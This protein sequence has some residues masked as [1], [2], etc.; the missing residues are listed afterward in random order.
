MIHEAVRRRSDPPVNMQDENCLPSL[1]SDG[2]SLTQN[3][4]GEIASRKMR[5]LKHYNDA[6]ARGDSVLLYAE[7]TL[8]GYRVDIKD[9]S[10]GQWHSLCRR[11]GTYSIEGSELN[12]TDEGCIQLGM[13]QA[14]TCSKDNELFIN[15]SILTWRGW[16]LV[17]PRPGKS[18]NADTSGSPVAEFANEPVTQF[19]LKT[20]FKAAPGSLP[21]LRFGTGYF[22]RARVVDIAGNSVSP[23]EEVSE[24]SEIVLPSDPL[25]F[26][27]LRYEPIISPTVIAVFP[28]ILEGKLEDKL[29]ENKGI[30]KPGES[31]ERL[32]I[33]TKNTDLSLDGEN[34][35][36]NGFSSPGISERY[37]VPPRT[38]QLMA[39]THGMFDYDYKL[40]ADLSTYKIIVSKDSGK[41]PE[42]NGF[43]IGMHDLEEVPY[44]PDP[45]SRGAAIR[46]LPGT[47]EGTIL[48]PNKGALIP[49]QLPGVKARSGSVTMIN[50]GEASEWPN[51]K[52]FRLKLIE[53]LKDESPEPQWDEVKR[54]LTVK[55]PKAETA[56]VL[57]SSYC[58]EE[59]LKIMGI[60]Q[61][62]KE[63]VDQKL[64]DSASVPSI[65][66]IKELSDKLADL[67]QLA[68]EGGFWMLTPNRKITLIHAVQQPIGKPEFKELSAARDPG[69]SF[70]YLL[71][72]IKVH[73]KSTIKLDITSEWSEPVDMSELD[74]SS[75]PLKVKA[76]VGE[77][78]LQIIDGPKPLE[79][80]SGNWV[81]GEY[82]P[83][84]DTIGFYQLPTKIHAPR[85]EFGDTK[86][87]IVRYRATA[88]SR[89]REYFS[90]DDDLDFTRTSDEIV[91]NIP[92]SARPAAPKVLYVIP[93]FGWK[94]QTST[95]LIASERLG[96]GLRI[97]LERPWYSSGE[98]EL[99]GVVLLNDLLQPDRNAEREK[100]KHY[101]TQWGADPIW[102]SNSVPSL[103]KLENFPKRIYKEKDAY[104][105]SLDETSEIKVGVAGHE[106]EYDPIR[107]LWY[108]DIDINTH[109][110]KN[111]KIVDG[112]G[113][114]YYPF[115]RLALARYQPN[116][117]SD[118]HLSK[119]V[120]ADFV[121]IAPDRSVVVTYDPY[122]PAVLNVAVAGYSYKPPSMTPD[123][124]RIEVVIESLAQE[125]A[126][127]LGWKPEDEAKINRD[128]E[129]ASE[130]LIWK[131]QVTLPP[132]GGQKFRLVLKEYEYLYVDDGESQSI[133]K[134]LV[135]VETIDL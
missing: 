131:G 17:A 119:V 51:A 86:H 96:G 7:D 12:I 19:K 57:L 64:K 39:E 113:S 112:I 32:V 134:R 110:W 52:P 20:S 126:G 11:E 95:N 58:E 75:G 38:S 14:T 127:D 4:R 29:G 125:L 49:I 26:K 93:T 123:N 33:R 18:I 109:K 69:S 79:L 28:K 67:T 130:N 135:F 30:Y 44:L 10:S 54:H 65:D 89:F 50:F 80:M 56:T 133:G 100:F 115:I 59:D 104:N 106:V 102:K 122:N 15:D 90:Q 34:E 47:S 70:A 105:L 68:L 118:A 35:H 76:Y 87:R 124:E 22:L 111:G 108:C 128:I 60:W 101:I 6:L 61:W 129:T 45:L 43:P 23:E 40:K 55:L 2:I 132:A 72:V 8:R 53:K 25:G 1:R 48:R 99:L 36:S 78:P 27:Y 73:G 82:F 13:V 98:G 84:T 46:N 16:S 63:Y 3:G 116:S 83:E 21:K 117:I 62:I 94:R 9:T 107:K 66:Q 31:L 120:L 88:S 103:P 24:N 71:G 91:V 42:W 97:Y 81:V 85:H 74:P 121:Q 92:S 5:T 41:F 114:S 37:V 77:V